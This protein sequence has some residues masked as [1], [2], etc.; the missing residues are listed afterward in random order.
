M[1]RSW[2]VRRQ[3]RPV[4]IPLQDVRQTVG[5]AVALERGSSREHLVEHATECENVRTPIHLAAPCLLG[6]H[7]R[8]GTEDDARAR[9]RVSHGWRVVGLRS[10]GL[11]RIPSDELRQ[12]EVEH[13]DSAFRRDFHIRRLEIAMD[14]A[15]V[16]RRLER[17]GDLSCDAEC[18]VK[19]KRS[20]GDPLSERRP[21]H[22]LHDQ[23]ASAFGFLQSVNRRNVGMI[24][25]RERLR[26][27]RESRSTVRITGG[28]LGKQLERDGAVQLR[29]GGLIDLT[30]AT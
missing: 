29:V 22:E 20:P 19:R 15:P 21:R 12:S 7:V 17:L 3:A 26:L 11:P 9:G 24:E 8:R 23:E 30:H 14:D 1:N 13:F 4:G 27:A 6:R 18:L 10:C 5:D 2:D 25:R 28:G 16:V